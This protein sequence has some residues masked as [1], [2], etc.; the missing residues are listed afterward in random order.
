[1]K[2]RIIIITNAGKV[3]A[4]NYC[5][6]VYKDKEN[7]T[8]FFKSGYGGYYADVELRIFDKPTKSKVREELSNLTKDGIEFSILIFCGHGWYS[9]VSNSNIF[10][11][12]DNNE[13]IDS[14]EFRV[15]SK[16][17]IVIEDNCRK[18]YPE[19]IAES[20]IKGF[21]ALALS[22][23]RK[24]RI[25]PEQCKKHYIEKISACPE[26]LIIGQACSIGELAG[27]SSSTGGYYSSSL[28]KQTVDTAISDL[29]SIDL[30][31]S[32]KSY[33]FPSSHN[34]AVP[35]VRSRSGNKQNPQIEKPRIN[36]SDDYLPF[37]IIA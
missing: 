2:R 4:D 14:L 8:S 17:R 3:G 24:Q 34:N 33:N 19:Y 37:A 15:G 31:K 28:L 23:A 9:T 6:G 30:S 27:D 18:A 36:D 21:S 1:M 20:L 22:A 26:Q 12:N 10:T 32:Y 13:E 35:I 16:K 7:Y 29:Q 11:L 5:E 25:D